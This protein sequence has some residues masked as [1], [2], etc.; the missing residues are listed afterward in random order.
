MVFV[1]VSD[2]WQASIS[3]ES[4]NSILSCCK[5]S[6]KTFIVNYLLHIILTECS[7]HAASYLL[8]LALKG[9]TWNIL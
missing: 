7:C 3:K 5:S 8:P 6:Q 1:C 9:E 4:K 2:A